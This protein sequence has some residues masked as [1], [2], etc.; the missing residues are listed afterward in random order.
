MHDMHEFKTVLCVL[1]PFKMV[2]LHSFQKCQMIQVGQLLV[3]RAYIEHTVV[4]LLKI[5]WG[6]V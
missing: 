1:W 4:L 2:T 5:P 6:G 3:A